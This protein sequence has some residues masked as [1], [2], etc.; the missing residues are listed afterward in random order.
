[1][2]RVIISTQLTVDGVQDR[3]DRWFNQHGEHDWHSPAGKASHEQLLAA[4]ALLLGRKNY[5]GFA[6]VWPTLTDDIGFADRVNSM[7]KFVASRSPID[8]LT[9]NA[10]QLEAELA[11]ALRALK[12]N[13]QGDLLSFGCGMFARQLVATGLV[14]ELRFWINPISLGEGGHPF[15]DGEPIGLRLVGTATFDTGIVLLRYA[16][17]D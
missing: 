6:A 14:D 10:Q 13:T 5:E 2:G 4:D 15:E 17:A 9:W 16:V 3:Q 8:N 1:M 12:E 7:P 11:P